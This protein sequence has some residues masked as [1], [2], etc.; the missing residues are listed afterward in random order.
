[1]AKHIKAI[2]SANKE[3]VSMESNETGNGDRSKIKQ[4]PTLAQQLERHRQHEQHEHDAIEKAEF[5]VTPA[6]RLTNTTRLSK[7]ISM[8]KQ[9]EIANEELREQVMNM[10]QQQDSAIRKVVEKAIA[11]QLPEAVKNAVAKQLPMEVKKVVAEQFLVEVKKEVA[12]Q[13]LKEV[14]KVQNLEGN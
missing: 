6:K 4:P 5:A 12:A 13:L 14:Q 10:K 1:M 7:T 8:V 2:N 11:V 3:S 9:L